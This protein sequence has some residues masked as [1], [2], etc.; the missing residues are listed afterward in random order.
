MQQDG[1]LDRSALEL[2][3]AASRSS[4]LTRVPR[5]CASMPSTETPNLA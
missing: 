5:V 2:L 1:D 4:I 3:A